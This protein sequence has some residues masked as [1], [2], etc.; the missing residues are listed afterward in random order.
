MRLKYHDTLQTTVA[1]CI[2][3][4]KTYRY[5]L[6]YQ[7]SHMQRNISIHIMMRLGDIDTYHDAA[8]EYRYIS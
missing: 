8:R 3:T 2:D 7:N 1:R 4:L 5:I 6:I